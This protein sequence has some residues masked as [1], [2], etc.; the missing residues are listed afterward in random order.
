MSLTRRQLRPI[1][2]A[3][4]ICGAPLLIAV[5]MLPV[6]TLGFELPKFVALTIVAA[7]AASVTVFS[8]VN[9][10]SLALRNRLGKAALIF[11]GVLVLST[12]WSVAPLSSLLGVSPRFHGVL[13]Y[14]CLLMCALATAELVRH[15]K[16]QALV[17]QGLLAA[18][19]VVVL[20]GMLQMLGLDPMQHVWQAE[21]FLGRIFS[22]I[23]HPNAL[24]QFIVL[25]VPFVGLKWHRSSERVVRLWWLSIVV[26]NIL[27]LFATASRSGFIGLLVLALVALPKLKTYLKAQRARIKLEQAFAL[28]LIVVLCA[29]LGFVFF[30]QRFSSTF[31]SGRSSSARVEIWETTVEMFGARP[32]G[33]G[34]ETMAF[35][36]PRFLD[37]DMYAF[38]SLTVVIDRAHNE[39]LQLL[40]T[41]GPLGVLAYA[42]LL[43]VLLHG[44][45]QQRAGKRTG[46]KKAA[47]AGIAA[48][49]TTLLFG[50][51]TIATSFVFWVLVGLCIGLLPGAEPTVRRW[52]ERGFR[53][54]LWLLCVGSLMVSLQ[55]LQAR[56]V[57]GYAR[58]LY[59]EDPGI[60]LATHQEGLLTFGYDRD[61]IIEAAE[62]HLVLA[63]RTDE[64]EPLLKSV[65][66]MIQMLR[67]VTGNEDGMAPVLQ[68]WADALRGNADAAKQ[69]LAEAKPYFRNSIV[70]HRAAAYILALIGEGTAVY[71]HETAIR[72]LLPD[73]YFDEGSEAR[74]I[75]QKQHPWLENL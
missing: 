62:S 70:Y 59:G 15:E 26:A 61:S 3:L 45:W 42:W 31:E 25:T 5:A 50:F 44:V 47:A 37:K 49:Q 2:T 67:T 69:A 40:A 68:A 21:A 72:G 35:V 56:W 53:T 8:G 27:V 16:T 34:M 36:S 63:E 13:T 71:E 18:N 19:A 11:V 75:L 17:H 12:L 66:T 52:Q 74:R 6:P 33:W 1:C 10:L 9:L 14:V 30:N 60:A 22:T 4:A 58:L 57:H 46:L 41:V 64:P 7:I 24:A 23:G 39:W 55:W 65:D 29:S 51:P 48:F 28:S 43:G 32:I 73:A 20:Y 38:E 54:L